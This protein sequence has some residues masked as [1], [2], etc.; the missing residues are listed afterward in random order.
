MGYDYTVIH[1]VDWV[2]L[3]EQMRLCSIFCKNMDPDK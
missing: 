3:L 1:I 2:E